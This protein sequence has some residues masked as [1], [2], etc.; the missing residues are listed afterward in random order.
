MMVANVKNGLKFNH[1]LD[2]IFFATL[3]LGAWAVM[4]VNIFIMLLADLIICP[5]ES[6]SRKLNYRNIKDMHSTIN[7]FAIVRF[8]IKAILMIPRLILAVLRFVAKFVRQA[9]IYVHTKNRVMCL[10]DAAIGATI[11]FMLGSAIIGAIAGVAVYEFN[12]Q[13]VAKRWLGVEIS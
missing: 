10:A 9:F 3:G 1:N 12:R 13:I 11:G 8:V 6:Y 2:P 7:P 5:T 4:V